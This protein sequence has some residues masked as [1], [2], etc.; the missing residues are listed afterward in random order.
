MNAAPGL[1]INGQ[2]PARPASGAC[3]G[4]EAPRPRVAAVIATINRPDVVAKTVRHLLAT[5]TVKPDAVIV[6]CV[7]PDDAGDLV[8]EG[9]V[10]VLTGPA[11]L[12]AQR[13]RAL[14]AI[15]DDAD[16]VVFFDDDFV[17]HA[18]WLAEAAQAFENDAR[19]VGFTG[20]VLADGATGPGVG[21]ED[22]LRLIADAPPCDWIRVEPYS[23]YGCNM[24]FRISAIGDTRFDERLVLYG[25]LED[26]DFAAALAARGGR[27]VKAAAAI[28]VHMGVKGGRVTGDRFGYSQVV[29]PLYMLRKG[30]MTVAQVADHLFR[31]LSSN[32]GRAL[33][34]EPFIDRRGRARGN[35]LA[36]ADVIRGRLEPERAALLRPSATLGRPQP[37]VEVR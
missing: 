26:R 19:V 29:N 37:R 1:A 10:T 9:G 14:A 17:A 2:A 16:I 21:F 31:N 35:L 23:P 5:Q 22:A 20:R 8:D 13:N 3:C 30:T 15:G 7:R 6:S 27:F 32:F 36:L 28:G 12:A 24:A 11:G 4:A 18:G 25:W 34:P 33:R